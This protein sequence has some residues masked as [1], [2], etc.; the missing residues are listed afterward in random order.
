MLFS[1][2][3]LPELSKPSE[4]RPLIYMALQVI[5][6]LL[7]LMGPIYLCHIS[8]SSSSLSESFIK[9][10]F[11][12]APLQFCF[13][14]YKSDSGVWRGGS[15]ALGSGG[16]PGCRRGGAT[17]WLTLI[18]RFHW[19]WISQ[20][21]VGYKILFSHSDRETYIFHCV[22]PPSDGHLRLLPDEVDSTQ[23]W[24][25]QEVPMHGARQLRIPR[26]PWF[27]SAICLDGLKEILS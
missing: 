26:E 25:T 2:K 21:L 18:S 14:C 6:L 15:P 12:F 24:G 11:T 13:M 10:I 8:C 9:R 3:A 22:S 16:G 20:V 23:K 17:D 27:W 7:A 1:T 5:H 19:T 4:A